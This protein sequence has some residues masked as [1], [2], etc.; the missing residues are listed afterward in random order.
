MFF[1]LTR[2]KAM[3]KTQLGRYVGI[4]VGLDVADAVNQ[5]KKT[6]L[7]SKRSISHSYDILHTRKTKKKYTQLGKFVGALV[8]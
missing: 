5:N 4:R 2:F 8:N 1:K 7:S 3:Y 6:I